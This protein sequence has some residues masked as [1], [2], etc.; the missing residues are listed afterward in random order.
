MRLAVFPQN[1]QEPQTAHDGQKNE[2]E[3]KDQGM[4]V[5]ETSETVEQ[6]KLT[7]L[8]LLCHEHTL[9]VL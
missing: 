3:Q 8:K 6:L 4:S 5:G 2:G 9:S 7:V 1:R